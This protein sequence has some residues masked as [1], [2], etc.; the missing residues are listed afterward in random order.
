[1][2]E[3]HEVELGKGVPGGHREAS[4]H[5]GSNVDIYQ[6]AAAFSP[7]FGSPPFARHSDRI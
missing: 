3:T 4:L 7:H 5:K 2:Q 1:M 6:A